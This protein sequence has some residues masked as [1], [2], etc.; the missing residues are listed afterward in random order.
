MPVCTCV[1]T[2]YKPVACATAEVCSCPRTS[3]INERIN[4]NESFIDSSVVSPSS[5]LFMGY[6]SIYLSEY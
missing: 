5:S 3:G 6:I 1:G 4:I 2:K